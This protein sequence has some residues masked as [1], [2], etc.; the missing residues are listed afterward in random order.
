MIGL[1]SNSSN[2]L[3]LTLCSSPLSKFRTHFAQKSKFK[4]K[5]RGKHYKERRTTSRY[6]AIEDVAW[7]TANSSDGMVRRV[8]EPDYPGER[9]V[10]FH[11][12][13]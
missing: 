1:N 5:R 6:R 10:S 3:S 2:D 13:S 4:A 11:S 7:L 9:S 8:S 12:K